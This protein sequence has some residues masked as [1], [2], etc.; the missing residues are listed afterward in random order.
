MLNEKKSGKA[1][2]EEAKVLAKTYG[3]SVLGWND[4]AGK[5]FLSLNG[6]GDKLLLLQKE[7]EKLGWYTWPV[8]EAQEGHFMDF[9]MYP[10]TSMPVSK[11]TAKLF[12][13]IESNNDLDIPV[14]N[15]ANFQFN[16]IGN[17]F[18]NNLFF[19]CLIPVAVIWVNKNIPAEWSTNFK[20]ELS[21][22]AIIVSG[23]I[24]LP[25]HWV[26][27]SADSAEL[28]IKKHFWGKLKQ[29]PISNIKKIK[30]YTQTDRKGYKTRFIG[31]NLKSGKSFDLFLPKKKQLEFAGFI[32][33]K[34][35]L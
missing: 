28:K 24:L 20:I 12:G 23:L 14:N 19:L 21:F 18:L 7:M 1:C 9:G 29:V 32:N 8:E 17:L 22:V 34:I 6:D 4:K 31:I 11:K 25:F 16:G 5:E 2:I 26:F 30:I 27:I 10:P 35:T 13:S 15:N 3:I 33:S